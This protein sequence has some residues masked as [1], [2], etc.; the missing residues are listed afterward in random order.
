MRTLSDCLIRKFKYNVKNGVP[1]TLTFDGMD[2]ILGAKIP[3]ALIGRA[4][5]S[6]AAQENFITACKKVGICWPG[7]CGIKKICYPQLPNQPTVASGPL[8]CPECG[9]R[10]ECGPLPKK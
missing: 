8:K 7:W 3:E 10:M 4:P 6:R 2:M 1:C 9:G 5:A